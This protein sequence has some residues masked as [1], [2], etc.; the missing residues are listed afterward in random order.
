MRLL[1][2][3]LT[4][5]IALTGIMASGSLAAK[6]NAPAHAEIQ[7]SAPP[8]PITSYPDRVGTIN[9]LD[10]LSN[11]SDHR[12]LVRLLQRSR[13]VPTIN[14]LQHRGTN[15]TFLAPIDSAW[16]VALQD[17]F[18]DDDDNEKRQVAAL[19]SLLHTAESKYVY[20]DLANLLL[21]HIVNRSLL[22]NIYDHPSSLPRQLES[23]LYIPHARRP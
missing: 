5:T 7:P 19:A 12:I 22:D 11:S 4:L 17:A 21:Y 23:T 3:L 14:R 15:L 2:P 9:I 16:P 18:E 6:D 1:A 10:L 8:W 20:N 13:L